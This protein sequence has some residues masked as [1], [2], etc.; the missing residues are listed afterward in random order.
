MTKLVSYNLG[1]PFKGMATQLDPIV[2]GAQGYFA[3]VTN[4]TYDEVA[5]K[6]M[7]KVMQEVAQVPAYAYFLHY[8]FGYGWLSDTVFL[9]NGM[10][11]WGV[12]GARSK[13]NFTVSYVTST[14]Q[15]PAAFAK[16]KKYFGTSNPV[17][18]G[19]V[20][21]AAAPT[22]TAGARNNIVVAYTY[23][24]YSAVA[25]GDDL[26]ESNPSPFT[27]AFKDGG[28]IAI[29]WPSDTRVTAVNVYATADNDPS[30][31][32]Y[33]A[34]YLI[35]SGSPAG[36]TF[37]LASYSRDFNK[38]L[39]WGP[40]GYPENT[41]ADVFFDHS[42]PGN[43]T[44]FSDK[45]HGTEA[46]AA[47]NAGGTLFY[48]ENSVVGWTETG[49]PEYCPSVNK[50]RLSGNVQAL[51]TLGTQTY[52]FL[53]DQVWAFSGQHSSAISARQV[54]SRRGVG[55][56]KAKTVLSTPYGI[57]YASREGLVI[58]DGNDT[59]LICQ[60]VFREFSDTDHWC[61][62]YVDGIYYLCKPG[63]SVYL[64]NA[65]SWRI[66][67]RNA[68]APTA[69][70]SSIYFFS[71]HTLGIEGYVTPENQNGL[72]PVPWVEATAYAKDAYT[73]IQGY[74]TSFQVGAYFCSLQ[75]ANSYKE[76]TLNR[77]WWGVVPDG[78]TYFSVLGY[79]P[80]GGRPPTWSANQTYTYN[81]TVY[82]NGSIYRSIDFSNTNKN[83][84]TQ[85]TYWSVYTAWTGVPSTTDAKVPVC[86][87]TEDPQVNRHNPL[88]ITI[89]T[90]PQ[91]LGPVHSLSKLRRAR[92]DGSGTATVT[93]AFN[94]D[95]ARTFARE[96]T[97]SNTRAVK[98]M[99]PAS[100]YGDHF[101]LKVESTGGFTLR[102][103]EAE[104][105]TNR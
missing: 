47:D 19:L 99:L 39:N 7:P 2:A 86:P 42:P 28:S 95:G 60:E 21:P 93:L 31:T 64:D 40:G 4:V 74:A 33:Y 20:A 71:S 24:N 91:R 37:S 22:P 11:N 67:L 55:V 10:Y 94:A 56:G 105:A 18:M 103:V 83:P 36:T 76:P 45:L 52:A 14:T 16:P 69:T 73:Y 58:F 84:A 92:V 80:L 102:Q 61:A 8:H 88:P 13:N 65:Q 75:A 78:K 77:A 29:V 104:G 98:F 90:H 89:Q 23:T 35:K 59:R 70:K 32:L 17:T 63:T 9:E 82:Y 79:V 72:S 5:A 54:S 41:V 97:A 27:A 25:T 51:V 50:Y 38:P 68:Q 87:Y 12:R 81:D 6:P 66:D 53:V 26:I 62:A 96:V 1:P 101:T 49:Q 43:V 48:A 34:G 44:C 30:G 85:T 46:S 15:S 3:N 57:V 100:L